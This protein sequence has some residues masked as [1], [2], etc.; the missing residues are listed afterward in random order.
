MLLLEGTIAGVTPRP[1]NSVP[2]VSQSSTFPF[3]SEESAYLTSQ[4]VPINP[5]GSGSWT[6]SQLRLELKGNEIEASFTGSEPSSSSV[7]Y[8]SG[9]P[10]S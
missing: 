3:G 8:Y 2:P 10:L 4:G 1:S 6:I 5:L 7:S 9:G